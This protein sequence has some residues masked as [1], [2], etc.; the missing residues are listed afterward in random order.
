[1]P[2][3]EGKKEGVSSK[4]EKRDIKKRRKD[5]KER[6]VER[7][8]KSIKGEREERERKVP[9]RTAHP[10]APFGHDFIDRTEKERS[11]DH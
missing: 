10:Y 2:R 11:H 3:K 7:R 6:T 5:A 4:E 8:S 9:C 1:M